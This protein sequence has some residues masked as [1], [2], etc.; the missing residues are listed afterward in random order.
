MYAPETNM[1]DPHALSTN[2]ARIYATSTGAIR[3]G[4]GYAVPFYATVMALAAA[5]ILDSILLL[6]GC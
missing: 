5:L 6:F 3:D 4:G 1:S 2:T